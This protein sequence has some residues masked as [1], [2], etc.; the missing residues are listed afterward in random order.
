[1]AS[2]L[3]MP[4]MFWLGLFAIA[5][6]IIIHLLNRRRFKIVDWAAMEFLLNANKKN[7]RRIQLENIILLILRCIAIFLVGLL[8]ARPFF[9]N[10][11]QLLGDDKQ[12]ERIVLL[13]DSFSM[14]VRTGNKS[15]FESAKEKLKE[16]VKNLVRDK[17]AN[18]LTLILAS[19]V[20]HPVV[21]KLEVS[22]DT[23]TEINDAI[24]EIRC[25]DVPAKYSDNLR[26]IVDETAGRKQGVNRVFYLMTDMREQDW[27]SDSQSE[28]GNP[29][30][31][32][33][34][35][36]GNNTPL[37][38]YIVDVGDDSDVNIAVTGLQPR[39]TLK[40]GVSNSFF[41]TVT[42]FGTTTVK[43]VRLD[44]YSSET[45]V[46][47]SEFIDSL[48]PGESNSITRSFP[49]TFEL[50]ASEGFEDND[51]IANESGYWKVW[52]EVVGPDSSSDLVSIDSKRYYAAKV[53]RGTSVLLVDG[54]P[55]AIEDRSET[56]YLRRALRPIESD[57]G[58][59][60]TVVGVTELSSVDF[61]KYQIIYLCNVDE[62]S[63][64]QL[65][66]LEEWVAEGGNLVFMLGD[67][68]NESIFNKQ[69]YFSSQK[70]KKNAEAKN[71][72]E[73]QRLLGGVGL[74]PLKLEGLEGDVNQEKWVNMDLGEVKS[75]ITGV[76]EG[77][78]NIAVSLVN[79]YSWWT[80]SQNGFD[81]VIDSASSVLEIGKHYKFGTNHTKSK[82]FDTAVGDSPDLE[83]IRLFEVNSKALEV[84]AEFVIS[85]VLGNFEKYPIKLSTDNDAK[86]SFAGKVSD[87]MVLNKLPAASSNEMNRFGCW[88]LRYSNGDV[89]TVTAERPE[90]V[91]DRGDNTKVLARF[92]DEASNPAIV[93]KR[94]GKGR[95]VAFAFPADEDWTNL[96]QIGS[97]NLLL[98]M[99]MCDYLA[100]IE[101]LET[102]SV[103]EPAEETIDISQF[104]TNAT[105][106]PPVGEKRNLTAIQS[107][108]ST[109]GTASKYWDI[110]YPAMEKSGFYEMVLSRQEKE[111]GKDVT[112]TRVFAANVEPIEGDLKRLDFEKVGSDYFG[113]NVKIIAGPK[114]T[115]Q[116]VQ[117]AR[118]EYWI[119]ILF[120]LG[121]ILVVEQFLGWLFGR[122]R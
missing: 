21:S 27:W 4:L 23:L 103:G 25:S 94:F 17:S 22:L 114:M 79:F 28:E 117:G 40:S 96:P 51:Q 116:T 2:F 33:M 41:V 39:S 64:G 91:E 95:V 7:R 105:M 112:E 111:D 35:D 69:F 47:Q 89:W 20:E 70:A 34:K 62:L 56:Y 8:L 36:I 110:G 85:D 12:F 104:K 6:P 32:Y 87:E 73:V 97:A 37:G 72:S 90:N 86:F 76:F 45:A 65:D 93:E 57:S 31:N 92:N 101:S 46:A 77:Q 13:D 84:G 1:M 49:V 88:R 43:N 78:G 54:D 60:P 115:S 100:D 113:P 118:T 106:V 61:S 48:E 14:N 108:G 107:V 38:C 19:D 99:E 15:V 50:T 102:S 98:H 71:V 44:F 10:D 82:E 58:I 122:R 30:Q 18:L 24:D 63:E 9:P 68:I 53:K 11:I 119:Y 74:S 29:A 109:S 26:T 67:Q 3:T 75:Q 5:S 83:R 59:I 66:T 42:N 52:A 120:L 80:S 121:G 81:P 16:F 55:S